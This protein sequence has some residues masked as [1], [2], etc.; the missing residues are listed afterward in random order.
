MRRRDVLKA[1]TAAA[2]T[3]VIPRIGRAAQ[4]D[5]LYDIG[6][7]GNAR[8]LHMTDSHAQLNPIYFREPSIYLGIG[9]LQNSDRPLARRCRPGPLTAA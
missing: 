3:G 5:D 1:L 7:F 4:A 2:L 8:V 9:A 6:R